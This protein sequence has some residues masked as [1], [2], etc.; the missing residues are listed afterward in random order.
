MNRRAVFASI[1]CLTAICSAI[2]LAQ[3]P[4]PQ[5]G[6]VVTAEVITSEGTFVLELDALRAPVSVRN[7]VAYAQAKH[8]DGTVFHRVID[9]FMIQGGG[10]DQGLRKRKT[11]PPIKNE[12]NNGLNNDKYT[13]AMARAPEPNS[14]T[15]Q[16]F[17]NMGNN[18]FLNH[19]KSPDGHGYAVFGTVIKGQEVVEKIAKQKT[20]V[21]PDPNNEG[22]KLENVPMKPIVIQ[23]VTVK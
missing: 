10:L 13:I 7:F 21:A 20:G 23:K 11:G 3:E 4:A 1:G 2:A 17:I 19:D 5:P 14:A 18:T 9:G 16:F 15:C 22:S 12:A 8:Y 6:S